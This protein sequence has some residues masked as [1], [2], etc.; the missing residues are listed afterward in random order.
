MKKIIAMLAVALVT[1]NA[2]AFDLA[3]MANKVQSA[4]DKASAKIEEAQAKND[5]KSAETQA[6]IEEK[7]ADLKAKIAKWQDSDTANSEGTLKA[8]ANAKASIEKLTEQLK[9]LKAA[10]G[11]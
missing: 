2:N 10:T 6:K 1:S 4:A 11:Y 9:A 7:I 3:K 8:I 5:A